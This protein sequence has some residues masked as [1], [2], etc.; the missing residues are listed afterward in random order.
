MLVIRFRMIKIT[1]S[2]LALASTHRSGGGRSWLRRWGGGGAYRRGLASSSGF[3][4]MTTI[5][6]DKKGGET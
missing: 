2:K 5:T 3:T 6:T 4:E 1:D